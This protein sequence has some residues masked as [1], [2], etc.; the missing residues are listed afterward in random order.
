MIPA[1]AALVPLLIAT[2]LMTWSLTLAARGQGR[3]K[4]QD[5]RRR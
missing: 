3:R 5:S 4:A 1:L 2:G